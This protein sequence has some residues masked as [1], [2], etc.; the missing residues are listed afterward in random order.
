MLRTP[1][2]SI[3]YSQCLQYSSTGTAKC[4]V[5][6]SIPCAELGPTPTIPFPVHDDEQAK[7]LG[8]YT[9]AMVATICDWLFT[10]MRQGRLLP[11]IL[12]CLFLTSFTLVFRHST[13]AAVASWRA[14][15]FH[16]EQPSAINPIQVAKAYQAFRNTIEP[17]HLDIPARLAMFDALCSVSLGSGSCGGMPSGC[18]TSAGYEDL[19][20][21]VWSN[22]TT[23][24]SDCSK[25]VTGSLP[26]TIDQLP[27]LLALAHTF[28][29]QTPKD[30]ELWDV[31]WIVAPEEEVR[32]IFDAV[33]EAQL[34]YETFRFISQDIVI[35]ERPQVESYCGW[36][37]QQDL[38][39]ALGWA[40]RTNFILSTSEAATES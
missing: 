8:G 36:H 25:K 14:A 11:V 17:A 16:A 39:L 30:S 9:S 24:S 35:R 4:P 26:V 10:T 13:F 6:I 38:K 28:K 5:L 33:K 37:L 21:Q 31:I 3:S 7:H 22:A 2:S 19:P 27:L 32:P 12:V 20:Y 40:A 1:I 34:L 29:L 15:V 18:G 23:A